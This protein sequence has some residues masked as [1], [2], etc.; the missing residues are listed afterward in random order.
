[1]CLERYLAWKLLSE[2]FLG[3]SEDRHC[4]AINRGVGP[5]RGKFCEVLLLG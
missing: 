1:M 3:L 4:F 5:F 2:F